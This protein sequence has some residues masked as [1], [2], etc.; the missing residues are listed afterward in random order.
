[1]EIVFETLDQNIE[2][3]HNSMLLRDTNQKDQFISKL[4]KSR[5]KLKVTTRFNTAAYG[6]LLLQ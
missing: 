3:Y 6:I 1:M 5:V 4:L 2:L